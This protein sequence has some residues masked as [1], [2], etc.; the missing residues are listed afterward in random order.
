[1]K[2]GREMGRLDKLPEDEREFILSLKEDVEKGYRISPGHWLFKLSKEARKLALEL[3]HYSNVARPASR[4]N[5]LPPGWPD[6][7]EK[8][9]EK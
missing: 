3:I 1:M 8:E 5:P 7:E 2:F 4:V 9:K 6:H